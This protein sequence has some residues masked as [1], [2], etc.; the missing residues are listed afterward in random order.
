MFIDIYLE[1][2]NKGKG[3]HLFYLYPINAGDIGSPEIDAYRILNELINEEIIV[4]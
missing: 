4:Y 1:T 2:W 3:T